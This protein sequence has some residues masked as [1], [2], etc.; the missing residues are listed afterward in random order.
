MIAAVHFE[1][2]PTRAASGTNPS[3]P[4]TRMQSSAT[5]VDDAAGG[6]EPSAA[7]RWYEDGNTS[8]MEAGASGVDGWRL[9]ACY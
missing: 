5:M 4:L 9:H 7:A 3:R 1:G 8:A 6:E 2:G